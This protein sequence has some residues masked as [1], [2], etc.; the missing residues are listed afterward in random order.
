MRDVRKFPCVF[1]AEINLINY[2][3]IN[4]EIPDKERERGRDRRRELVNGSHLS[5]LLCICAEED[6]SLVIATSVSA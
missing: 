5:A 2:V 1:N 3:I 6:R 4:E